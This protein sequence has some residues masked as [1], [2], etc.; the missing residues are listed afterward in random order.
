MRI[1]RKL[2]SKN[3]DVVAHDRISAEADTPPATADPTAGPPADY[4]H[5][6]AVF[7]PERIW[8]ESQVEAR[9]INKAVRKRARSRRLRGLWWKLFRR[10]FMIAVL[11]ALVGGGLWYGRELMALKDSLAT[12]M[13]LGPLP[14][15]D[16]PAARSRAAALKE[17][18]E[19]STGGE[20]VTVSVYGESPGAFAMLMATRA[21]AGPANELTRL[22]H[23]KVKVIGNTRCTKMPTIGSKCVRTTP[24]LTVVIAASSDFSRRQ[25]AQMVDEAWAALERKGAQ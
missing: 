15:A 19:R 1:W 25:T 18:M 17:D 4:R 23:G 20:P 16:D 2:A 13:V 7:D 6:P 5:A 14:R 22:S 10:L 21:S 12:P 3:G 24:E 11:L 8:V 9:A